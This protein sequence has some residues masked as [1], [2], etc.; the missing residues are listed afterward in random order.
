MISTDRRK[1]MGL[2]AAL[3]SGLPRVVAAEDAAPTAAA[4]ATLPLW[5]DRPPGGGAPPGLAPHFSGPAANRI[6][7]GVVAPTLTVVA[8]NEPQGSALLVIPGGG[9]MQLTF[10]VEGVEIA[11]HFADA[12]LTSF[13]LTYRLPSEG[14]SAGPLA[15]L[16]D[17]I[18]AIRLI[19]ASASRL[20]ID[21]MRI[22]VV[23]FS[24]G[25][26]L[27]ASLACRSAETTYAPVDDAD[28]LEARPSFL[29]LGYPVIT[30]LPPY[31]HE[32]SRE[33]L[34]GTSATEEARA[35]WSVERSVGGDMPPTFLFAA[36]DDDFV[37]V[38]NTLAMFAALRAKRIASELHLFERGG[39]GFGLR[40]PESSTAA[41]WPSLFLTWLRMHGLA[42][43]ARPGSTI[44]RS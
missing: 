3:L 37:P 2:G 42:R 14:W 29:A 10:D 4:T 21:S 25:G 18:R 44:E 28:K 40:V 24:A 39:H 38:D 43:G 6:L 17:A 22:G 1:L 9:Y 12:G 35:A 16:Q 8:P 23:G 34:L 41:D 26:H 5:P 13:I 27:A 33:H 30:M 31:A 7:T 15:P 36:E 32:A 19:R 20:R 11:Q